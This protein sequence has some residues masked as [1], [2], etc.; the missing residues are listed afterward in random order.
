[1][2]QLTSLKGGWLAQVQSALQSTAFSVSLSPPRPTFVLANVERMTGY[3][4]EELMARSDAWRAL[5]VAEDHLRVVGAF[6]QALQAGQGFVSVRLRHR[7]GRV[8]RV[9]LRFD[10]VPGA[11]GE[12]SRVDGM[13]WLDEPLVFLRDVLDELPD[14]V[15]VVDEAGAI[16]TANSQVAQFGWRVD[17]LCGTSVE[18]LMPE[19]YR[20]GHREMRGASLRTMARR[21]MGRG[22]FFALDGEGREIPVDI[23]LGPL[24][25]TGFVIAVLRDLRHVRLLESRARDADRRFRMTFEQAA[26]GLAHILP[27]GRWVAV[28]RRLVDISGL[29]ERELL[30]NPPAALSD[31]AL[32]QQASSAGPQ[33]REVHLRRPVGEPVWVRLTCSAARDEKGAV[34][35]LVMVVEDIDLLRRTD[36]LLQ[37]AQRLDALGRLAGGIA[38]DFNNLLSVI[39]SYSDALASDQ[40][41]GEVQRAD[42]KEIKATALRAASLTRQLLAFSKRQAVAPRALD[43]GRQLAKLEGLLRPLL[44][45]QVQLA[46]RV[47]PP[48]LAVLADEAQF[49]QVLVNLAVNARDA[50]PAGGR[51]DID[52]RRVS[53]GD[54]DPRGRPSGRF[55]SIAVKDE[56]EGI[57][58]EVLPH[59]FEPF[60]ST[61]P[62]G[63]GTGLG[64]ATVQSIIQQNGG[65]IEV[66]SRRGETVFTV[67]LPEA[68]PTADEAEAVESATNSPVGQGQKVLVVDD[69]PAIRRLLEV[70]LERAG[71]RVTVAANGAEALY[72]LTRQ[73][74]DALVTDVE[75]PLLGGIE[76]VRQAAMMCPQMRVMFVTAQH[77][78]AEQKLPV[79]F[80]V[81]VKPFQRTELLTAVAELLSPGAASA[82]ETLS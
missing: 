32:L 30:E 64:L 24:V 41:L 69:D 44:G 61:K 65:H 19:R 23:S 11:D 37:H 27:S 33:V 34:E 42:A 5:V 49:E 43:C 10:A 45:S 8:V 3:A 77:A 36:A 14:P 62:D 28:N 16:V 38:H 21:P 80:S 47:A 20:A 54:G 29:S 56:G 50:M 63:K 59:I 39:L 55:V 81:L 31:R 15:I 13:A 72:L 78:V 9:Q 68:T 67:L 73:R 7:S 53:I 46:F 58:A 17:R 6:Q 57:P 71:Y 12:T 66:S 52:V 22:P 48:G 35:C 2:E 25:G 70:T 76:L 82:S 18:N 40:T 51:L 1:V 79:P 4:A 26:V 74:F 60:F 75:M